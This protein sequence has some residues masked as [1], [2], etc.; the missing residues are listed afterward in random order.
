MSGRRNRGGNKAQPQTKGQQPQVKQEPS[1]PLL[2][3]IKELVL[4]GTQKV[5]TQDKQPK[6]QQLDTIIKTIEKGKIIKYYFSLLIGCLSVW[7][8]LIVNY[9]IINEAIFIAY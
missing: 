4:Q 5:L 1:N 3:L 7:S 8:P 6:P 9:T 2:D